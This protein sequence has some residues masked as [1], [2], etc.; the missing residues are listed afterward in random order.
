MEV[1]DSTMRF[2]VLEQYQTMSIIEFMGTTLLG[3]DGQRL[4]EF[5][6]LAISDGSRVQLRYF[7]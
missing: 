7:S 5:T 6:E 4:L 1:V 2:L 3:G